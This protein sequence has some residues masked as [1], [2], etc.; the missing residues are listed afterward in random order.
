MN[1][2]FFD[3]LFDDFG[4]WQHTDGT[5]PIAS[6]GYALDDA[7][8]GLVCCLAL[9]KIVQA[10]TLFDYILKSHIGQNYYGYSNLGQKLLKIPASDDAIGQTL[11]AMGYCVNQKYRTSEARE[12]INITSPKI[13]KMKSLRG[14]CYALLGTIYVNKDLASEIVSI[15]IKKFDDL[16]DK[17]YWPEDVVTYGN[18]I[19]PYSLLRFALLFNNN[20]AKDIAL[21]ALSFLETSCT[22][23]RMRGPIG[24]DGWFKKGNALPAAY[25]Q[26]PI[27]AAYMIWAWLCA[28]QNTGRNVDLNNANKWM[29][30]FDGD[31]IS[32]QPMFDKK[33]FQAYNG[34]SVNNDKPVLNNHSGA[35]TNICFLLSRWML[36]NHKTI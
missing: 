7:T 8:R 30:W 15:I 22:K 11:W 29:G 13:L 33:T 4:I 24:N 19:V 32:G 20:K 28:Y 9:G 23:G 3:S 21:R 31:N 27:D 6:E 26:Q 12:V 18:G 1:T 25:S 16:E 5:K 36:E 35:E 2:P 10:K 34:I 17:W 14:L